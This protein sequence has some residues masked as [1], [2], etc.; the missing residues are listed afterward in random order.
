MATN[1]DV[2]DEFLEQRG[3]RT[4]APSW[5]QAYNKKQCPECMGLHDVAATECSVCGW[6]P[7]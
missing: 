1:G 4:E 3:H 2:F 6:T 7:N 5:D